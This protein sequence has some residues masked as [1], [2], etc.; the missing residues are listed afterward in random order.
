[1]GTDEQAVRGALD[2]INRAWLEGRPLEAAPLLHEAMVTVF[3]VFEGQAEGREAALKGFEDFCASARVEAYR[4]S[5][6][7]V[8]AAGGTAVASYAY[9]LVYVRDGGR[10]RATG[11]D[12][13]VFTREESGWLAVW[14]TMIDVGEEPAP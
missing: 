8:H 4:E 7:Q 9:D 6:H 5:D 13:W 14:R 11:R 3:P 10:Y 1:M 12:L 2:R